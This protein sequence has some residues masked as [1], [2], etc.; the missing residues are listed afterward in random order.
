MKLIIST[1][2][3]YARKARVLLRERGLQSI[4]SE[5][6]TNVYES[7]L[8]TEYNPLGRVPVLVDQERTIYDSIVIC[9][10][11][12]NYDTEKRTADAEPI[13][14]DAQIGTALA[15]GV[16]D[17]ALQVVME[18]RRPLEHQSDLVLQRQSAHIFRGLAACEHKFELFEA[19][20]D[21]PA[22]GLASALSY[23]DFRLPHMAWRDKNQKLA[24]WFHAISQYDSMQ[25][26]EFRIV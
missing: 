19:R 7:A 17:S 20:F 21:I 14:W 3:P 2:S 5:V 24:A 11:L 18:H 10:Y 4:V 15:D 22:V 13:T 23:L 16:I 25:E 26:T 1:T 6:I 8:V 12:N 9:Q